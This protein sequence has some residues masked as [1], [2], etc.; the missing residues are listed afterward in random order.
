M[1][2]PRRV[3]HATDAWLRGLLARMHANVA[4]VALAAKMARIV[5]ALLQHGRTCMATPTM[6]AALRDTG[7]AGS[8][9][10]QPPT[11]EWWK[12]DDLSVDR[13]P[14]NL[15]D[16]M[17]QAAMRVILPG[18]R[19]LHEDRDARTSILAAD[20]TTDRHAGYVCAD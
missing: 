3:D 12:E 19:P 4:V 13:H 18:G 1:P 5:W 6:T 15:R 14:A 2:A 20:A 17:A 7:S 16:K 10:L 9:E 8:A 11:C